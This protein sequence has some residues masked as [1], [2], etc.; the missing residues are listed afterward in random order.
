MGGK[1]TLPGFEASFDMH[2]SYLAVWGF[3]TVLCIAAS[4]K[5]DFKKAVEKWRRRKKEPDA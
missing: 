4:Y 3:V 5:D 2:W 1:F